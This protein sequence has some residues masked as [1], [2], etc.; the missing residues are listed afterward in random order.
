MKK[1]Y[2]LLGK[3]IGYSFSKSFFSEKFENESL[4][5]EYINFDIT[6]IKDIV[7]IIKN[8][9]VQGLNVTI[10]YKEEIIS[11]LDDLDPIAKEIGAVNVIKFSKDQKIKGY[12][13]DYYGFTESLKPLLNK[14]IK[15]AL[16]L[17]TG[18]ASKAISYA[19]NQLNIEHTFV[20]R[21]PDFNELSYSDLDEDIMS[22]YTLIIN[23]TPLGTYPNV[24][25]YPDIPYEYVTKNH[26]LY[27]L[28]YNPKETAFM[29]KG[30]EKDAKVS[31]G[32]QMLI[33]QAKKAWEIWN[34]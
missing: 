17:G 8:P 18:G 6:E 9:Q 34:N 14:K 25:N 13:S 29:S 7:D 5:C 3:N 15:K 16:I 2:G 33:L 20:S 27:D 12:N 23:C 24:Q 26:V 31:N 30:K 1:T 11:Y 19:L 21:N 22:S 4:N 10:P 28:I 32:L